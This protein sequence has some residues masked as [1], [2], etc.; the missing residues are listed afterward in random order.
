MK[1][2]FFGTKYNNYELTNLKNSS[3]ISLEQ[4]PITRDKFDIGDDE[5]DDYQLQT[6]NKNQYSI[7]VIGESQLER[8]EITNFISN[9]WELKIVTQSTGHLI[10]TYTNESKL[11]LE[12]NL[13]DLNPSYLGK[14]LNNKKTKRVR[15]NIII[16]L[17]TLTDNDKYQEIHLWIDKLRPLKNIHTYQ[18][19]LGIRSNNMKVPHMELDD[20]SENDQ[21]IY[22]INNVKKFFGLHEISFYDV[23]LHDESTLKNFINITLSELNNQI[24][25]PD[26]Y[27][28]NSNQFGD[29]DQIMSNTIYQDAFDDE[30]FDDKKYEK[31]KE[32]FLKNQKKKS[33]Y[34]CCCIL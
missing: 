16:Y 27:Y 19:G 4:S 7:L 5:L 2:M 18:M 9:Q 20:E 33:K 10:A 17:F 22:F 11:E 32:P 3:N 15:F 25:D 26:T 8:N 1:K 13:Y 34:S 14:F 31:L 29:V 24:S 23:S 21:E 12:L 30:Y 6:Q 28:T